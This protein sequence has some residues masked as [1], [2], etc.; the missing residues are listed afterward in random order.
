MLKYRIEFKP[1]K[2]LLILQLLTY[3]VLVLS[4][5]NWQTEFIQYQLLLEILIVFV[6][7]FFVFRAVLLSRGQTQP[8]V[9]FSL[10]G[11]WLETNIDGQV[12]WKITARSRVSSLVLFVHLI[13]PINARHSKWCLIYRDQVTERDFRRLCC[14]VNYQQHTA[15]KIDL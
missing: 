11:E 15:G 6:I 13:S 2:V 8:P 1:S 3:G 4:V 10:S 5:L 12:G 14:A 7:T 9:V